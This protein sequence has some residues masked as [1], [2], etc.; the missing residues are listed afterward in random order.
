MSEGG[1][2]G[3]SNGWKMRKWCWKRLE[4]QWKNWQKLVMTETAKEDSCFFFFLAVRQSFSMKQHTVEVQKHETD[5]LEPM[6]HDWKAVSKVLQLAG[7]KEK[8]PWLVCKYNTMGIKV[9]YLVLCPPEKSQM[10]CDS[11]QKSCFT[12]STDGCGPAS[13]V[14]DGT[15]SFTRVPGVEAQLRSSPP[16]RLWRKSLIVKL[17]LSTGRWWEGLYLLSWLPPRG[18]VRRQV[19]TSSLGTIDERHHKTTKSYY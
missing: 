10:P 13:W 8:L 3:K 12:E 5:Y 18:T 16:Q 9:S 19:D 2:M 14:D 4:E 1:K 6:K 17:L 11:W 15:H 7:H